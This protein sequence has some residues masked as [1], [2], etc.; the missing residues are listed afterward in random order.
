MLVSL[1]SIGVVSFVCFRFIPAS[2]TTVALLLLLI[3]LVTAIT[4]RLLFALLA[5]LVATTCLDLFFLPPVGLITIADPQNWVALIVFSVVCVV[6]GQLSHQLRVQRDTL[7][8]QQGETEKLHLL[9]RSLLM[10]TSG[11]ELRRLIANRCA[12]LFD[13]EDFALFENLNSKFSH[14]S[15][16]HA[17]PEQAM[18]SADDRS[19]VEVKGVQW[20]VVPVVLGN[21]RYGSIAYVRR[22]PLLVSTV[23]SLASTIAL[24]LAQGQ[25]Q[26]AESRSAAVRRS[27]ELKSVMIDALAHDL[28]TPLTSIEAAAEMLAGSGSLSPVQ[29]ADMISVIQE[30]TR[31]LRRLVDE[32]THLARINANRLRLNLKAEPVS[33]LVQSAIHSLGDRTRTE[34]I[35]TQ[36]AA[37]ISPVLV[38]CELMAQALKQLLDNA[39]KYGPPRSP[40]V[41]TAEDKERVITISVR[42]S[43]PG[44]TELEQSRVFDKFYRG[45]YDS[46]AIQGTGMGLSIAREIVEAHGGA[47]GVRSYVGQ[48]TEFFISLAPAHEAMPLQEAA[49]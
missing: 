29:S 20:T 17:L 44:L 40:V 28:K 11:D 7:L 42:D 9:S 6:A 10:S 8:E 45:R 32:A 37:G 43:G 47:V 23:S 22:N 49:V 1:A 2:A 21:L 34:R 46:S 16:I 27:E 31:G 26:E 38:D 3:V 36:V 41:L 18:R 12:Q 48:G 15:S 24:G 19:T 25:A 5:A 30:E 14:V 39:L 13:L 35:E 4:T 33:N